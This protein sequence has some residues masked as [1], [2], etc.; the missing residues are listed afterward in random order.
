MQRAGNTLELIS[1][2]ND[3]LDR[4]QMPQELRERIDK[5]DY[6]K[7]K[8]LHNKKVM[9]SKLKMPPTEWEKIFVAIHHM[10]DS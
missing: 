2:G 6:M 1:I 4:I 8:F 7:L 10:R 3:F 9:V 5:C